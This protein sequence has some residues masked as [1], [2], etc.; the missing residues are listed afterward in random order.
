MTGG[1]VVVNGPTDTRNSAVDYSGGSFVLTGG[2]FIGTNVDGRNSEGI[3]AGSTQPS[4]Y[5]TTGSIVAAGT[6]VH[7]ESADGESLVTFAPS[8]DYS[9]VVFTSDGLVDGENYNVYLG[10][11]VAGESD[12]SLYADDDYTAGELVGTV[13][14]SA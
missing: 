3:G 4:L 7:I 8:N 9:V 1:L 10:G 5:I 12:T 13:L 6:V 14:A 2:T 11:E